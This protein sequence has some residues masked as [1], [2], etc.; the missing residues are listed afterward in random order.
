[1]RR[2]PELNPP[3]RHRSFD[4]L[5]EGVRASWLHEVTAEEVDSFARLSG[6]VNPLHMDDRFARRQGFAGR[7][8]HGMLVNAFISRMLGVELPGPGV[9]WLS[10]STRFLLP[11]H[12]GDRIEVAVEVV[13]RSTA[14]RSL[15]LETVVRKAGG[16]TALTGEA[17]VMMLGQVPAIP[18]PE[19][20][21]V[22]TGASR[23]IGA[24][25]A[26]ALGGQG[27]G[28]V[29]NFCTR[30]E[31]AEEVVAAIHAVGGRALAVQGDVGT[32]Q[33]AE[34]VAS[35]AIDRFGAVHILVNNASPRIQGKPFLET[36]WRDMDLYWSTYVRSAFLLSQRL[37]PGMKGRG[38]G[39]IVN[40][41]SSA[42]FG[43]PPP[44]MSAYVAAKSALWGLSRAMAVELAPHGITVNAIS[45][46][47]VA[48]EQWRDA[49]ES[50]LRA[51]AMRN[52]MR[53]MASP[54]DVA[55]AVVYLAGDQGRF[56]T[57][58]NLMLAG[59]EVM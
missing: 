55:N 37:A 26:L 24:A 42:M 6:D 13:H 2:G 54:D 46:S 7:V 8:V 58:Q 39:R 9:L 27:A 43:T 17:K 14:T 12:I 4:E 23:G 51:M 21:A 25:I 19:A 28:V 11:V 53:G 1:V 40:I 20:V 15:V 57:G 33:G 36:S 45:P 47:A 38:H 52:P 18:W 29:V 22:V 56:V 32:E 34:A 10:Q 41:L 44:A 30:R 35:A 48:T 3:V 16:E 59:G 49:P 31:Q 50:R 5:G